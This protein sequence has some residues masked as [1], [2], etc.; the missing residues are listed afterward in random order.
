MDW[1]WAIGL[2]VCLFGI[3]YLSVRNRDLASANVVDGTLVVEP[4]G[5]MKL[6]ALKSKLVVPV[7]S[8]RDIRVVVDRKT[9]PLGLRL[10]GTA[11]PRLIIAG[12]YL[13]KGEWAFCAIRG[14][15]PVVVIEFDGGRY[16]RAIIET[17]DPYAT[18]DS[19]LAALGRPS[20]SR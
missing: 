5:L 1:L 16:A 7:E 2:L 9:I 6:W 18:V 8:V 4:R 12:S 17:K 20:G 15:R 3:I 14:D 11:V 10:P 19:T 13:K